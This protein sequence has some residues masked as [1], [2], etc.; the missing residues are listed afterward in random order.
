MNTTHNP[1]NGRLAYPTDPPNTLDRRSDKPLDPAPSRGRDHGPGRLCW[2]G[3]SIE[4]T[5]PLGPDRSWLERCDGREQHHTR[6]DWLPY[7]D[8]A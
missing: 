5:G 3:A 8:V 1:T 7:V 2:C 4:W 6:T